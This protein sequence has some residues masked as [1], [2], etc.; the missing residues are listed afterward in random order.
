MFDDIFN[1]TA[2]EKNKAEISGKNLL[3]FLLQIN[4]IDS[5]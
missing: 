5:Y 2:Q 1:L 4:V 3:Y